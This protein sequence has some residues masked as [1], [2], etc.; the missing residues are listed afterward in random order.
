MKIMASVSSIKKFMAEDKSYKN[1]LCKH[2]SIYCP[3]FK[4]GKCGLDGG[5]KKCTDRIRDKMENL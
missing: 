5:K 1:M 4:K 2:Y 3:Y